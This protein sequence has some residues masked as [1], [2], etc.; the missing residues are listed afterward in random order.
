M[1]TQ[2][3]TDVAPRGQDFYLHALLGAVVTVVTSFVPFSP[4][5]GGGVAGY[6]HGSGSGRGTKVGLVSGVIASL[7]LA[8]IFLFLFSI[9]SFGSIYTGE[10]A[11]PLFVI[12]L[13]GVILMFAAL[14]IVGLSALGGYVGASFA[15][16]RAR[17]P[18][19]RERGAE[20]HTQPG[21]EETGSTTDA[22]DA[23]SG[24]GDR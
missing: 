17:K 7:P 9:M 3:T 14:Y 1:D 21:R 15:E 13:V 22:T 23:E 4:L 19:A 12:V 10:F 2:T 8:A 16:S 5:I 6:L 18:E 24:D 20:R 11:G